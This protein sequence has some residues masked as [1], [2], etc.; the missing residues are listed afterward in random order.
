M[1]G[2]VRSKLCS[3]THG[4]LDIWPD[5]Q[6]PL[7]GALGSQ[8]HTSSSGILLT[9]PVSLALQTKARKSGLTPSCPFPS[10]PMRPILGGGGCSGSWGQSP[11]PPHPPLTRLCA[12]SARDFQPLRRATSS[13]SPLRRVP[14]AAPHS[15]S[16][17]QGGYPSCLRVGAAPSTCRPAWPQQQQ[18]L[19]AAC[20]LGAVV[21]GDLGG[22]SGW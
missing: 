21:A 12:R 4:T 3:L 1:S 11:A 13:Q 22:R 14:C 8:A 10:V 9:P 5:A 19:Q 7:T 18:R 17:W 20:K 2:L 6:S 16:P 15:P